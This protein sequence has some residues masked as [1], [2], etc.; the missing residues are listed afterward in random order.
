MRF[1]VSILDLAMVALLGGLIAS[2][3][4]VAHSA[5]HLLALAEGGV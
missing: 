5:L 4:T 1:T 3:P 2:A